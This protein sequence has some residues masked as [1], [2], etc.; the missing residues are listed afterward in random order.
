MTIADGRPGVVGQRAPDWA[1]ETWRR[2][3]DG[4]D[5]LEIADLAGRVIY[6]FC[7]QSWCPGCHS[8]GFPAFR[9]AI[10]RADGDRRMAFV[11]VQTVFEGS[12]QNTLEAALDTVDK[13]G[14]D[15]P[16]GHT[17]ATAPDAVPAIMASYRTGGTP[18]SVIIGPDR[19]VRLEGFHPEPHELTQ[20]V[21]GL[22]A[23]ATRVTA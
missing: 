22:L 17:V 3:P 15:V 12:Q 7:F 1:V 20:T 19:L 14:L 10:E 5:D 8:V 6:L 11:A 4:K 21:E 13:F 9:A 2:L 16:L 18:W 23:T